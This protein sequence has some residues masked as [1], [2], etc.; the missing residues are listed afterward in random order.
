MNLK[1]LQKLI[2]CFYK[3]KLYHI[4][5]FLAKPFDEEM[6]NNKLTILLL[7]FLIVPTMKSCKE[8]FID[9][10]IDKYN[11]VQQKKV[12]ENKNTKKEC[13]PVLKKSN[14]NKTKSNDTFLSKK[15]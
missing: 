15:N 11:T 14:E 3:K 6:M 7:F 1:K 4:K 2:G 8:G 5:N 12:A 13:K 9:E 10:M